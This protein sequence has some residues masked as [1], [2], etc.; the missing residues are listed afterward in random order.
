MAYTFAEILGIVFVVLGIIFYE[1]LGVRLFRSYRR[2][3]RRQ[4]LYISLLLILGGLA[5]LS[6][7]LEQLLLRF[8]V[9]EGITQM[10]VASTIFEFAELESYWLVGFIFAALAWL[11][12][13]LA[14]ISANYFTQ[15]FFPESNKKLLIIPIFL[16]VTWFLIM[17]TA[18]FQFMSTG[19]DWSPVHSDMIN[20]VNAVLFLVPLWTVAILFLYLSI[21]L[22]RRNVI[23]WRRVAW[24]FFSQAILSIGFTIEVLNPDA[25]VGFFTGTFLHNETLWVLGSR[26][27][28]MIYAV[29]MY[30]AFYTPN[31]AKG[32]L[33]ASKT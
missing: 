7:T 27:M 23:A 24:L 28:I 20:A 3:E 32:M 8:S 5:L 13:G 33:G 19:S 4:T 14:I 18:P 31:W 12:S 1:T 9:P 29:L 2:S 26:F 21:S 16:M 17:F 30:I 15:S 6:L 22:K 10:D 11:T 25:F